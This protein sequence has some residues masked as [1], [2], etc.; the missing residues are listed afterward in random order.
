MPDSISLPL[1]AQVW[2][3]IELYLKVAY[4]GRPLPLP[5]R[6]R[7]DELRRQPENC[8]YQ[9]S[10]LERDAGPGRPTVRLRLGN[11][12]YP[13]MKLVLDPRPVGEGYLFRAD[14]HDLHCCPDPQSAEY[15]IFRELMRQNQQIASRIEQAWEEAGLPTFKSYLRDDLSGR[16]PPR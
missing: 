4:E 15:E 2:R 6:Q 7:L 3:A 12:H 1:P 14:T 10:I 8:F 9:S 13:H 11:R 16:H 5:V